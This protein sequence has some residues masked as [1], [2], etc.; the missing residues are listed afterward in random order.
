MAADTFA[1][2]VVRAL[3]AVVLNFNCPCCHNVEKL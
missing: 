3:V 2:C 1:L